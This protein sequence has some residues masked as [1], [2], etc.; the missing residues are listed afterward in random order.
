[1]P[2]LVVRYFAA[3]DITPP[4]SWHLVEW[5]RSHDADEFTINEM[6]IDGDEGPKSAALFAALA[7]SAR[8]PAVRRHLYGHTTNDLNRS[9]ELWSLT[10]DT[11]A[12]LRDAMPGG[13]FDYKV[14]PDLWLEDLAL[15][16]TGEFMMGVVTHEHAGVLR[17]TQQELAELNQM[18]FPHRDHVPWVGY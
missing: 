18:Q 1:M 4:E 6:T 14:G 2:E 3:D 9:T 16:R 8:P 10:P 12:L 13:V 5:C 11:V 15:Y 17:V 7:P